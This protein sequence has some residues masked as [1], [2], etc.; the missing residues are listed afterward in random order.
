MLVTKEGQHVA[1]HRV[2]RPTP[3]DAIE[4]PIDAGD[5]GDI[6]VNVVFMRDGR[7]YRAERRLACRPT[8]ATLQITL[9]ADQAVAKPQ[10]ARRLHACSVTDA[11]A[12]RCR[13]R[14][15]SA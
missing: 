3:A 10:R 7:L 5:V 13:R 8:I 12:R 9:T 4:V 6:Y 14:S 1:W 15:A 2:L 11:R